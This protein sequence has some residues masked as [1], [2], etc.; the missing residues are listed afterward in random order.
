[1]YDRRSAV[2]TLIRSLEHYDRF[3]ARVESGAGK[4]ERASNIR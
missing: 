1:M 2:E 4:R 3:R